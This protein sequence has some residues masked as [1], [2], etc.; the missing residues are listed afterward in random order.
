[1]SLRLISWE[2]NTSG[3]EEPAEQDLFAQ[4][5]SFY[6]TQVLLKL[7]TAEVL[8]YYFELEY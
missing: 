3:L 8:E 4:A 6:C 5:A 1:M 7:E 2:G